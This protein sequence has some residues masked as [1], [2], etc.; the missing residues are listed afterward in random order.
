MRGM[1]PQ[2]ETR[3]REAMREAA[4]AGAAALERDD[5]LSAVL[6][7]VRAMEASGVFNA[8]LGAC[9]TMAGDIEMDAAVMVGADRS[10]GAVASVRG[11]ESAVT[12]ADRVRTATP[13]CLLTGRGAESFARAQGLAFRE[14][15]PSPQRR[16]EWAA[17]KAQ[18]EA[19]ALAKGSL[20]DGLSELGGVLGSGEETRGHTEMTW[21]MAALEDDLDDETGPE[22]PVGR[23]D[24]VGAIACDARGRMAAAVSTGGIWLKMPGRVGDSP[25]PGAGIWCVDGQGAAVATGTGETILRVLLCKEVV[26]AA[27]TGV[28]HAARRGIALLERHFGPDHAGVI[29]LGAD[30]SPG[31]AL[32]TRGMGRAV[33][34]AGMRNPAVA[35]WPDESWD[36]DI[37]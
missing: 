35:I 26:D 13:H 12:L 29:A 36:R 27:A 28:E 14:D 30:G 22:V 25:L 24:T 2:R 7:A 15:F 1:S 23:G 9:M 10:Y 5:A 31:F 11:I 4:E 34:R 19:A 18:L 21:P 6:D 8:G 37:R 16:A 20:R 33:L 32:H 17:K 3:Y